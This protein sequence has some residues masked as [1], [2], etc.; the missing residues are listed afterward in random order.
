MQRMVFGESVQAPVSHLID[1]IA[2]SPI[3]L[4]NV[5]LIRHF[6]ILTLEDCEKPYTVKLLQDTM[7]SFNNC[8]TTWIPVSFPTY[9]FYLN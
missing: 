3:Q 1:P 7:T 4:I 8:D 5:G 2:H 6:P 9:Y